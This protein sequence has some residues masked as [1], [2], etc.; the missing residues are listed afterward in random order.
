MT[1]PITLALALAAA[2]SL[3]IGF[4]AADSLG[5]Y[6][7]IPQLLSLILAAAALTTVAPLAGA[8]A[9]SA[10]ALGAN[11]Y[12]LQQKRSAASGPSLCNIDTYINCD[13][14]NNSAWSEA[15]GVPITLF[16]IGLYAGLLV[17]I[18]LAPKGPNRNSNIDRLLAFSGAAALAYSVF[19]AGVSVW[20]G[21]LCVVC[22]S[23]YV[24]NIILL[25]AGWKGIQ[26]AGQS[27]AEHLG[28]MLNSR[29]LVAVVFTFII[30]I[31]TWQAGTSTVMPGS[32]QAAAARSLPERLSTLYRAPR[33]SP[34]LLASDPV[35]GDPSAPYTIIEYAD[36]GCPHCAT[37]ARE[38][39]SLLELRSDI[40]LRFRPFPLS[41]GCNDLFD[42][43]EGAASDRC[44]AAYAA[45]CAGDQG[46]FWE[47]NQQLFANQGYFQPDDLEYMARKVELDLDAWR[48]CMSD[49][50]TV[51]RVKT[52]AASGNEVGIE[53]TPSFFLRGAHGDDFVQITQGVGA[54]RELIEAHADGVTLLPAQANRR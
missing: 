44:R 38:L 47:M 19:L 52:I 22:I 45:T 49:P 14:L 31:I 42:D 30:S 7:L 39:K 15:F 33:S 27:V 20:I 8:A 28:R 46:R 5:A 13:T 12:L 34:A 11:A 48:A 32:N 16:G 54:L 35:L 18:V 25:W 17:A 21:A 36:Y 51:E 24:S 43:P 6:A 29:E 23:I 50:A 41:G 26:D 1:R 40:S 10:V 3:V 53:G 4:A 9:A 37:A 2:A